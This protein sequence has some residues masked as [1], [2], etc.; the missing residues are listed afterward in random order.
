MAQITVLGANGTKAHDRETT[1]F[2]LNGT[3][4]ID[5][6]NLLKGMGEECANIDTIWLTH[7]HLDHIV[8]IAYVLDAYFEKRKRPLRIAGLTQTLLI[9]KK[10]FLN[11]LIWP[12]FSRIRLLNSEMYAVEYFPIE[13]GKR[14]VIGENEH[15]EAFKTNHTVPSCGYVVTKMGRSIA[16][17]SDTYISYSVWD[18]LN[19]RK[20]I[21]TL[22]IECSFHNALEAL[23]KESK[24]LTP[25]LLAMELEK[26]KRAIDIYVNHIKPNSESI[27]IQE[28]QAQTAT[29]KC[30]LLKDGDVIDF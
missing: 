17:T 19:S 12:D 28:L 30:L 1:C 14:Y 29:Q 15:I 8:D 25:K 5:A 11:E 6:G 21:N 26:L 27:I 3:H 18:L 4:L 22:I 23:A 2:A 13:I 20:D 7:S 10:H 16:I 24:H 9:L